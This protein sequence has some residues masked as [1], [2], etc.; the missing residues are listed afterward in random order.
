VLNLTVPKSFT[1]STKNEEDA[2][3]LA[4]RINDKRIQVKADQEGNEGKLVITA[5]WK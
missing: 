1:L 4:R 5:V 3:D 2:G